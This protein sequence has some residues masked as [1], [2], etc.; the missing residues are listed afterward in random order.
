V[1]VCKRL[2]YAQPH[3]AY[4]RAQYIPHSLRLPLRAL[5]HA[6]SKCRQ[7]PPSFSPLPLPRH[8]IP[9]PPSAHMTGPTGPSRN[10]LLG[11]SLGDKFHS[12][13]KSWNTQRTRRE[14]TLMSHGRRFADTLDE[15]TCARQRKC[16]VW[17]LDQIYDSF[18]CS[19]TKLSIRTPDTRVRMVNSR[20][21]YVHIDDG[22]VLVKY[23]HTW[24]S[25]LHSDGTPKFGTLWFGPIISRRK[26]RIIK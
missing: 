10:R 18:N 11:A 13:W 15:H 20:I 7:A 22:M 1:R 14:R 23:I 9:S 2:S 24:L 19:K 8:L 5:R 12:H 3:F 17:A 4:R 6:L 21:F 26:Q 16:S 25:W